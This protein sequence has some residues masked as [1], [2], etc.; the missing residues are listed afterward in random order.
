MILSVSRDIHILAQG[1]FRKIY[2]R[3]KLI[4]SALLPRNIMML[5]TAT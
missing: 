1:L 5:A 4:T 2:V 3:S